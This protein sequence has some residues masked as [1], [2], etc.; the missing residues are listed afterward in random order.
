MFEQLLQE[1]SSPEGFIIIREKPEYNAFVMQK[2]DVENPIFRLDCLYDKL[3][4][5]ALVEL[6]KNQLNVSHWLGKQVQSKLLQTA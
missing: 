1:E 6:L 3:P 5:K 4:P 2:A